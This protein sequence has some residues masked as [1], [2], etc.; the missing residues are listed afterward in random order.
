MLPQEQ[1]TQRIP[2]TVGCQLSITP[3]VQVHSPESLSQVAANVN[4]LM[5]GLRSD[6]EGAEVAVQCVWRQIPP[7]LRLTTAHQK[8][9]ETQEPPAA[10]KIAPLLSRHA[11]AGE[12]H[13]NLCTGFW[14][15]ISQSGTLD[16]SHLSQKP[17]MA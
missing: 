11:G 5:R 17:Y 4:L 14:A 12:A 9:S 15:K 6:P 13:E 8:A 16:C 1:H 10:V 3:P 2:W 7:G